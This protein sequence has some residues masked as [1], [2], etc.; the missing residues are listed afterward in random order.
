MYCNSREAVERDHIPPKCF[1]TVPLPSDLVVVPICTECNQDF[2]RNIDEEARVYLLSRRAYSS[3]SATSVWKNR[4]LKGLVKNYKMA[5]RI[6]QASTQVILKSTDGLSL[7]MIP[8]ILVPKDLFAKFIRRLVRGLHWHCFGEILNN[9]ILIQELWSNGQEFPDN[10]VNE[11][12]DS[13]HLHS[14]ASG[15]FTFRVFDGRPVDRRC[16]W[17]FRLHGQMIGAAICSWTS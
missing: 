3:N 16:F 15:Q 11:W 7:G 2:S 9:D 17:V 12:I 1:F 6:Q 14:H 10:D 4:I 13:A 8:A 5:K